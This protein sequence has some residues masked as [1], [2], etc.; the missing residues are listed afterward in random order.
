[1]FRFIFAIT[2]I[3]LTTACGTYAKVDQEFQSQIN[4]SSEIGIF[5]QQATSPGNPATGIGFAVGG[6]V[7]GLLVH[8]LDPNK[9]V[10]KDYSKNL[11]SKIFQ[12]FEQEL[13][14]SQAPK[15]ILRKDLAYPVTSKIRVQNEQ[16]VSNHIVKN[17]LSYGLAIHLYYGSGAGFN[18]PLLLNVTWRIF[19]QNG[20][21]V[22]KIVTEE[23]NEEAGSF[24]PNALDPKNEAVYLEL[25]QQA[26]INF[27]KMLSQ[28]H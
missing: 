21:R 8:A 18:K 5:Y 19:D 17:D 11:E 9:A 12:I 13:S 2:L 22:A 6:V 26:V 7:G 10:E 3:F 16:V 15:Y 20:N 24:W 1:M 27:K 4:T 14:A 25:A 28:Q 23:T